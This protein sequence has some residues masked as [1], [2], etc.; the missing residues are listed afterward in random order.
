MPVA[1]PASIS[2]FLESL[3]NRALKAP[4]PET[5]RP[6]YRVL[7]GIGPQLLDALPLNLV[8]RL[9]EQ[10]KKLLQGVGAEDPMTDLFCLAVLAVMASGRTEPIIADASTSLATAHEVSI[11]KKS[12][13]CDV[14]RQYLSKRAA[15]TLDLVVLRVIVVCSR[16][17]TLTVKEAIES[18]QLSKVIIDAVDGDKRL[19]MEND[20]G[21]FRKLVEKVSSYDQQ[22]EVL[23]LVR[24]L[25][26]FLW[27]MLTC[28]LQRLCSSSLRSL[29]I[30]LY[31]GNCYPYA[32]A[33]SM[34]RPLR[35]LLVPLARRCW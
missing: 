31:H 18:L 10:F 20:K 14:A 12:K 2:P 16:S 29:A 4:S 23:C 33:Y 30:G 1:I 8:A 17:C 9:Q 28:S 11:V 15:K 3:L 7:S 22:P 5:I 26:T 27:S 21:K 13:S 25:D 32:R 24:P 19:W 34:S 6:I 35:T